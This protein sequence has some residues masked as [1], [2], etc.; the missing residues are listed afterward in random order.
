M[1]KKLI[2]ECPICGND[3]GEVYKTIRMKLPQD[4]ILPD[5]YEVVTCEKCG[6]AYAD[7][8]GTQELYNKY[9]DN[10]NVYSMDAVL[11]KKIIRQRDKSRLEFIE[12][13]VEK[14]ARILDVGSGSG[15]LLILLQQ[16]GFKSL[17]GLDPSEKSIKNLE[18]KGIKGEL[19]NIF[20]IVPKD[21]KKQFDLVCFTA[22]LEHIYDLN[23]CIEQLKK[24]LADDGK[25]YIEVPDVEGFWDGK[26]PV[27][28]YFNQEHINYF[29]NISL[30]NLLNKH[31]MIVHS[32]KS[33]VVSDVEEVEKTVAVMYKKQDI[34]GEI[35]KDFIAGQI[36][37][38]YFD[39]IENNQK[40]S[41]EKLLAFIAGRKVMIWGTG[42]QAMQLLADKPEIVNHVI[43]FVDNNAVKV[44]KKI[45]G[46]SI[47]SPRELLLKDMEYPIIIC[48]MQCSADIINQMREMSMKNEYFVW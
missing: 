21:M 13:T 30:D 15:A 22:V 3:Y 16:N 46:I 4:V 8:R 45:L 2:R 10:S 44:G 27:P 35:N 42:A 38:K 5:N 19:R 14:N 32:R 25:I 47:F 34:C 20:D 12:K 26:L 7:V 23:Q 6:F 48:S 11:R 31:G 39:Y 9:Y 17:V 33:M 40:Q 43:G 36:I 29:S 41:Y 1:M 37:K 18:E 24:Y 28:H